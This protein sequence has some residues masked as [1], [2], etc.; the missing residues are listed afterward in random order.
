MKP[1]NFLMFMPLLSAFVVFVWGVE[2]SHAQ[3]LSAPGQFKI[4]ERINQA[5][6]PTAAN[7]ARTI[8]AAGLDSGVSLAVAPAIGQTPPN[9]P[10]ERS[11]PCR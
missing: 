3:N 10:K 2:Q 4:I 11:K 6:S 5:D 7:Q 1:G 9:T 8:R